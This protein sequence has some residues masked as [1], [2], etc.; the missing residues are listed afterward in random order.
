MTKKHQ[1]ET[2][3]EPVRELMGH[4]P[5]WIVRWGLGL[6]FVIFMILIVGSFFF[7]STDVVD[8]PVILTTTFP[9]ANLKSKSTGKID[10]I[11]VTD[12][13]LIQPGYIVAVVEN[14]A[15][16]KDVMQLKD[17]IDILL[18]NYNWNE[19]F[20]R[21]SFAEELVL[22]EIQV[23]YISFNKKL[24]QFRTYTEQNYLPDKIRLAAQQ[25]HK[26]DEYRTKIE[27]QYAFQKND[28][29]LSASVFYRD[30]LLFSQKLVTPLE[31]EMAAQRYIQ[32][33]AAFK[34]FEASLINNE[35]STLKARETIIE[36]QQQLQRELKQYKLDLDESANILLSSITQWEDRY[37]IRSPISG[38]ITL[39]NFWSKNQHVNTGDIVATVIPEEKSEIIGRAMVPVSGIGKVMVGQKVNISLSGYPYM[40]YGKVSGIVKSISPVPDDDGYLA[41]IE[42]PEGMISK[43]NRDLKYIPEMTGSAEIITNDMP[44]IYKFINPLRS[45][46]TNNN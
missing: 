36:L 2:Y 28:L 24:E 43:Y 1:E 37:V 23:S 18:K 46:I 20:N 17:S 19:L 35:L 25:L 42:L 38:T 29:A 21:L 3:S 7:H 8:T 40:E 12:G 13:D 30:S 10:D 6:F 16:S 27:E 34:G 14:Q 45:I 33:K 4:I 15:R 5:V 26:Q 32:K 9:P 39:T 31:Y 22:G 41:Y 11:F 44:L